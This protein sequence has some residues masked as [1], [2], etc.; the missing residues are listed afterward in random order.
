L[1]TVFHTIKVVVRFC[2]MNAATIR[3][4]YPSW[5]DLYKAALF[6][7]DRAKLPQRISEARNAVVMR[8]RELFNCEGNHVEETED[9]EDALY[10]LQALASCLLMGTRTHAAA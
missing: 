7:V 4:A 10:A 8:G 3:P 6:E 9:L 1:F 5:R 2:V